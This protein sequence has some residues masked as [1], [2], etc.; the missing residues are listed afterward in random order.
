MQE[1]SLMP[2]WW[3]LFLSI[4][5]FAGP[6]VGI[7]VGAYLARRWQREQ[8]NKDNAK[9]ECRELISTI[10]HSFSII[11]EYHAPSSPEFPISGPHTPEEQQERD[12]VERGSLEIFYRMIFIA[13]ELDKRNLRNRWIAAIRNYE[14]TQ[15]GRKFATEFGTIAGEIIEIA[16]TIIK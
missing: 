6:L 11:V 5:G 1:V 16:H 7:F 14:E 2:W 8:W 10:T 15:D 9:E 13:S 4:W 3:T 12:Q